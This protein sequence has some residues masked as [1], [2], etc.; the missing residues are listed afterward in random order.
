MLFHLPVQAKVI[1]LRLCAEFFLQYADPL[2]PDD[3]GDRVIGVFNIAY[4]PGAERTCLNAGG[5]Q[6]FGDPV[7]AEIAFFRCVIYRMEEPDAVGAA[8]NAVSAPDTPGPV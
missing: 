3:L 6:A 2:C 5:L 4:L 7:I 8:H 1:D